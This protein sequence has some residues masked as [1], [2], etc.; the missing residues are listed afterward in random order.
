MDDGHRQAPMR[1]PEGR[2]AERPS[3]MQRH[4]HEQSQFRSRP[5]GA[6]SA[7]YRAEGFEFFRDAIH[8]TYK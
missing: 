6:P 1:S 5:G 8:R 7:Q 4:Q 3:T 2:D